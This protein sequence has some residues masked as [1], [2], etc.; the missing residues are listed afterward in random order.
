MSKRFRQRNSIL[1]KTTLLL[2]SANPVLLTTGLSL[3]QEK[4]TAC[5]RNPF[6]K[7]KPPF[8]SVMFINLI[9]LPHNTPPDQPKTSQGCTYLEQYDTCVTDDSTLLCAY[10][11]DKGCTHC[12]EYVQ[13]APK[14]PDKMWM[15]KPIGRSVM[16][17]NY[18]IIKFRSQ[19]N[20]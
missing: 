15:I 5:Q 12:W 20:N 14:S 6:F 8:H 18:C 2:L 13:V 17:L 3:A 19:L 9:C 16:D 1:L 11:T 7:S 10:F 4:P